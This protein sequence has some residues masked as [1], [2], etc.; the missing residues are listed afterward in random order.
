MG[1]DIE[2][3][4]LEFAEHIVKN[5]SIPDVVERSELFTLEQMRQSFD[6]GAWEHH[7]HTFESWVKTLK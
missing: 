5:C 2:T 4:A 1:N 6:A 7:I 3:F